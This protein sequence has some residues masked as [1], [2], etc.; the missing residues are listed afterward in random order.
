MHGKRL[1]NEEPKYVRNF[2]KTFC[3]QVLN[4]FVKVLNKKCLVKFFFMIKAKGKL[5]WRTAEAPFYMLRKTLQKRNF[6]ETSF[7]LGHL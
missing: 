3:S 2:D 6:T 4:I 5:F 1:D 7:D